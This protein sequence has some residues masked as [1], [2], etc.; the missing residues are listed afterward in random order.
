M[1]SI[2]LFLVLAVLFLI[3]APFWVSIGVGIAVLLWWG[4]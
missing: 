1:T 4:Q 2:I 3:Y